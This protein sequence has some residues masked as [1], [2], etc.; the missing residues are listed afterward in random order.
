MFT[1]SNHIALTACKEVADIM[2][3][4][5]QKHEIKVFNYYRM[6][7]NGEVIRLS[8]DIAWTE[9]FFN[10]GY[11]HKLT[12]PKSYLA[13][14]SNYFIWLTEDCPE[15]LLDAAIN[16]DTSNGI[17]IAKCH[18]DCIEYFCYA[19]HSG[20][21]SIINNFYLNNLDKLEQFGQEFKEQASALL[22]QAQKTKVMISNT[23]TIQEESTQIQLIK[24][25]SKRQIECALALLNGLR[26]K[27]IARLL[28][29]SP[30]T[31]EFY[32]QNIKKRLNCSSQLELTLLLSNHYELLRTCAA[33]RGCQTTVC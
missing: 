8:T 25:L 16:F 30:R 28:D 4:K 17:S 29:L 24:H 22:S 2:L 5:L 27:S 10:K 31:I 13:K 11:L 3:P 1:N 20:N 19:S 23:S 15:I 21:R 7:F 9:H 33:Q 12:V 14:P 18:H 6:Y 32:L 26:T